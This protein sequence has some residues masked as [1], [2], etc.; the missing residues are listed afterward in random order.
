M[1]AFDRS[2]ITVSSVDEILF[3]ITIKEKTKAKK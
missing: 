1:G 2:L 3:D